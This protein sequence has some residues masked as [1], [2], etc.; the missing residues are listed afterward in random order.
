MGFENL[1]LTGTLS[2]RRAGEE[3]VNFLSGVFRET[4]DFILDNPGLDDDHKLLVVDDQERLR[5]LSY[6]REFPNSAD[7]VIEDGGRPVGRILIETAKGT[8]RIV[9]VAIQKAD[10][11]QGIGAMVLGGVLGH[12]V[13]TGASVR[14]SVSHDNPVARQ[15]YDK[16]GFEVENASQ[17]Q[18]HLIWRRS[19]EDSS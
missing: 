5:D 8:L 3:D 11:R 9:D 19:P 10:R 16:L 7:F 18:T 6:A 17:T 15:F 4:L 13:E 2:L 12:A 14:L 1:K